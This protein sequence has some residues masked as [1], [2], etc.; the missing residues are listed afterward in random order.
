MLPTV[1]VVAR[2]QMLKHLALTDPWQPAH[3]AYFQKA[4]V[5]QVV[6]YEGQLVE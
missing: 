2:V 6:Y 5:N 3:F 4:V 1:V